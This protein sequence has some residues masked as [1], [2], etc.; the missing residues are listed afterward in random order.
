[1]W[2]A[3]LTI[4][5]GMAVAESDPTD[6][7]VCE[8]ALTET[9]DSGLYRNLL[10]CK[11]FY[12]VQCDEPCPEGEALSPAEECTCASFDEIKELFPEG[13][14][15]EDVELARQLGI[16]KA[17]ADAKA[18]EEETNGGGFGGIDV[19]EVTE[20]VPEEKNDEGEAEEAEGEGEGE[21]AEGEAG[22]GGEAEGGEA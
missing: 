4:L 16:E 2:P 8:A 9:C 14:A 12:V 6:W 20:E 21:A 10:A 11:C 3:A 7:P 17:L 18:E 19:D 1:M 15:L 13:S 5:A 22:E